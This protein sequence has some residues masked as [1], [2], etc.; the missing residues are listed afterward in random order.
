MFIYYYYY[1]YKIYGRSQIVNESNNDKSE[2][3]TP[4]KTRPRLIRECIQRV[5][6][7]SVFRECIQG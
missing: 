2:F 5:Y 7:E 6:S 3:G 4:K 1:Y